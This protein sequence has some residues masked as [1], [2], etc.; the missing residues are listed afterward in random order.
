[1]VSPLDFLSGH[2]TSTSPT[3]CIRS[4]YLSIRLIVGLRWL[5]FNYAR[6]NPMLLPHEQ[7][8]YK[9]GDSINEILFSRLTNITRLVLD[10]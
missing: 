5:Y 9:Y 6:R 8:I 10:P 4:H 1:M 3:L 2:T 7:S